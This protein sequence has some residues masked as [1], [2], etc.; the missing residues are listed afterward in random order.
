M[1]RRLQFVRKLEAPLDDPPGHE[2]EGHE[3]LADGRRGLPAPGSSGS[4]DMTPS[5]KYLDRDHTSSWSHMTALARHSSD[6]TD[7]NTC[8]TCDLRFISLLVRS[9][10]LLV[11]SRFQWLGGKSR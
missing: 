3:L 2:P 4:S 11:R 8:T 10:R 1:L 7:G 9:C 6:T 5:E